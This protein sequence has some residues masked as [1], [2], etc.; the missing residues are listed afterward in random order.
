MDNNDGIITAD[1]NDGKVLV[2]K[3][4]DIKNY[5]VR[6]IVDKGNYPKVIGFSLSL[7]CYLCGCQSSTEGNR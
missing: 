3:Q 7:T 6:R 5:N 2:R 4:L 1:N